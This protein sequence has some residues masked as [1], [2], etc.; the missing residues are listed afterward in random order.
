MRP[1][2]TVSALIGILCGQSLA[3]DAKHPNLL[4]ILADDMGWGE[5][6]YRGHP[7]LKTP[8][9]DAMA[10]SGLRFERFYAGARSARPRGPA[11]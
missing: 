9:L 3:A 7:V 1:L 10:A 8:H 4:F 5:T 2:L 6:G 11:C